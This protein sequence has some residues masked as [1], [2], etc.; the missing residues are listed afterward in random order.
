MICKKWANRFSR[1]PFSSTCQPQSTCCQSASH[2]PDLFLED[3]ATPM[4]QSCS[5]NIIGQPVHKLLL[6]RRL[7][8]FRENKWKHTKDE[9]LQIGLPASHHSRIFTTHWNSDFLI[10]NWGPSLLNNMVKPPGCH[11]L[12]IAKS[13]KIPSHS[14][15]SSAFKF[16]IDTQSSL[17]GR[18]WTHA[19]GES[20]LKPGIKK[21][22][23]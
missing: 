17:S 19:L 23:G 13:L 22:W 14:A 9:L 18:K 16:A 2:S 4:L 15:L 8:Q 10:S 7:Q 12:P 6:R 5:S 1:S 11:P 21:G 20:E 3:V